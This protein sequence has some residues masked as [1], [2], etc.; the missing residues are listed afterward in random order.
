MSID[1][2][3]FYNSFYTSRTAEATQSGT[4][5]WSSSNTGVATVH[6]STGE[7]TA[8]TPGITTISYTS[9]NDKMN[10]V[11]LTVYDE[12]TAKSPTYSQVLQM[13]EVITASVGAGSSAT[14]TNKSFVAEPTSVATVNTTT[15]QVTAISAGSSVITYVGM[16]ANGVVIEKGT[17]TVTVHPQAA[18]TAI[19]MVPA[20]YSVIGWG[21]AATNFTPPG[22]GQSIIWTVTNGTGAATIQQSTGAIR[23]V[24]ASDVTVNYKIVDNNTRVVAYKSALVT[25]AIPDTPRVNISPPYV[26]GGTIGGPYS[27]ST[28]VNLTVA[29]TGENNS[30]VIFSNPR[31]N[32]E[33]IATATITGPNPSG[34]VS[35]IVQ[36]IGSGEAQITFDYT[37]IN[38]NT[39]SMT[40]IFNFQ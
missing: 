27:M 8:H 19:P 11:S 14:A 33:N 32:D 6:S 20:P 31:S 23:G 10:S 13:D 37:D 1:P 34:H 39:G 2:Y 15:G 16:D 3:V 9:R 36:K 4:I 25:V 30:T 38:N 35:L 21:S 29:I 18:V 5:T 12:A 24:T 17:T 28:N 22:V 7:I 26:D 40:W